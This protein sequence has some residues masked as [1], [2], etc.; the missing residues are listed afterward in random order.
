[1][2]DTTKMW[3]E[4]QSGKRDRNDLVMHYYPLVERVAKKLSSNMPVPFE[5]LQS[6]GTFGLI[7]AIEKYDPAHG[8]RFEAYAV[9]RIR[10]AMIDGVRSMDWIPRSVRTRT[11]Q[12]GNAVEAITHKTGRTPTDDELSEYTGLSQREIG[13][14]LQ[15]SA[16][17]TQF[18]WYSEGQE[19]DLITSDGPGESYDIDHLRKLVADLFETFG[20]REKTLFALYYN[21]G[22]TLSDIGTIL[23]VTEARACQIHTKAIRDLYKG[24]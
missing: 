14:A 2:S 7:D 15:S 19:T 23:G 6:E 21:E 11:T 5:D 22:L 10:G 4:Y 8:V 13:L 24:M 20:E 12:I 1:M 16:Q 3:E 9:T 18:D 17:T